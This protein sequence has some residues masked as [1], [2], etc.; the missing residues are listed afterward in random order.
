MLLLFSYWIWNIRYGSVSGSPGEKVHL[1]CYH[2]S[3]FPKDKTGSVTWPFSN[4][5]VWVILAGRHRAGRRKGK[6]TRGMHV[7]C[8]ATL[9][10]W[11]KQLRCVAQYTFILF[12]VFGVLQSKPLSQWFNVIFFPF[13]EWRGKKYKTALC[14]TAHQTLNCIALLDLTQQVE[15]VLC[16]SGRLSTI[17]RGQRISSCTL[18]LL[19]AEQYRDSWRWSVD[20]VGFCHAFAFAELQTAL[21]PE[22]TMIDCGSCPW[23]LNDKPASSHTVSL[24]VE[25]LISLL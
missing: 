6:G 4:E 24:V 11:L 5:R 8:K 1:F 25:W 17:G 15:Q 10:L 2:H 7:L 18:V 12:P 22:K 16:F 3:S 9:K 23:V 21:C 13:F 14:Q 19:T 20:M